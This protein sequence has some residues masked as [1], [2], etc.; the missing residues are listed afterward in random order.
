MLAFNEFVHLH[1][2]SNYSLLEGASS[3]AE[4][5]ARAK[6]FGARALAL[7]DIN[8]LYGIPLFYRLA[9]ELG[10][11]PIPGCEITTERHTPTHRQSTIRNPQCEAG[12][13]ARTSSKNTAGNNDAVPRRTRSVILLARNRNGYANLCRIVTGLHLD[14]EFAVEEA[15]ARHGAD[16]YVLCPDVNTFLKMRAISCPPP[17]E[18]R[19]GSGR[20]NPDMLYLEVRAPVPLSYRPIVPLSHCPT[21]AAFDV[22]YAAPERRELL[23][24]LLA[25][26]NNRLI[27]EQTKMIPPEMTH[28]KSPDEVRAVF[29]RFVEPIENA[30]R[31]AADCNAELPGDTLVFPKLTVYKSDL[32]NM[33]SSGRH[34]ELNPTRGDS[35]PAPSS[36][37]GVCSSIDCRNPEGI[38]L[39]RNLRT[40]RF[41][42]RSP[43]LFMNR[44]DSPSAIRLGLSEIKGLSQRTLNALL[45]ERRRGPDFMSLHDLLKRVRCI[46]QPEVENLI[47]CGAMESL[48]PTRSQLMWEWRL[49][50]TAGRK[51]QI[52]GCKSRAAR[53]TAFRYC[54]EQSTFSHQPSTIRD[55]SPGTICQQGTDGNPQSVIRNPQFALPDY[56]RNAKIKHEMAILGMSVSGHPLERVEPLDT[57]PST[58]RHLQPATC[59]LQLTT[60]NRQPATGNSPSTARL[61]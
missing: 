20:L 57:A 35:E 11:K 59:N 36:S 24:V 7:T 13:D 44:P 31:I 27:E 16:L 34:A 10:I 14:Q 32:Q 9:K 33:S 48:G 28:L 17:V 52:A 12:G 25:I 4:L 60:G 45:E 40:C 2:H 6:S 38:V 26:K 42:V 61:R 46:T 29:G 43:Q 49:L 53:D 56:S 23:Q 47:L 54:F 50:Q 51:L 55:R 39:P 15:L 21:V 30:A 58:T 3:V 5:L 19:G 37:R 8:G 22:R 1:V 41:G 18:Q